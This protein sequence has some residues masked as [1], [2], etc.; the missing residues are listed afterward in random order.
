MVRKEQGFSVLWEREDREGEVKPKPQKT[1][2]ELKREQMLNLLSQAF[3]GTEKEFF[4]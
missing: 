1:P 3:S 2:Q 4:S